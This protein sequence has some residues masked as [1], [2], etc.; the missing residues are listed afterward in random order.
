MKSD[1]ARRTPAVTVKNALPRL[2]NFDLT[3]SLLLALV[4]HRCPSNQHEVLHRLPLDRRALVGP[5]RSDPSLL[6]GSRGTLQA[7]E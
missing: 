6:R 2:V 4:V 1:S 3:S 7:R 5:T